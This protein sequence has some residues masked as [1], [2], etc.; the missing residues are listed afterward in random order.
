M[1]QKATHATPRMDLGV[2]FHEYSPTRMRFIA[3]QVM[4]KFP[5][6]K[7]AATLSVI[8][9]KNLTLPDTTRADGATFNRVSLYATDKSYSC[10]NDALEG[11]LPDGQRET[12]PDDFNAEL[13]TINALKIKMMLKRESRIKDKIFDTTTWTGA[14]LYTD[15]S[16]SPRDSVDTNIIS[17]IGA[18][19]EKV[20]LNTGVIADSLIIGE[21]AMQNMLKNTG[22]IARFPN[23]E[24]VT[25]AMIRGSLAA[26][27]GLE[28]LLVGSSAYNSADEG[29]DP[30][31]S[32]LW[33]DDYAMVAVL[34]REGMP[35][36][37]PQLARTIFWQRYIG[38]IDV[39]ALVEQ[40]REQQTKSDIFQVERSIDEKIIDEYFGHLMK[41][42]A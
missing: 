26:I 36:S 6:G 15:N 5:V 13:E 39:D 20:R 23:A 10:V 9:R 34:G 19:K 40:Y 27:F 12:Y 4:P 42:D 41:I 8:Q 22:I 3:D 21:A 38:D 14:A 25:E 33:G 24:R 31:F 18:A 11:V 30:T 28:Q 2:A 37:E 32:D 16:G 7:K 17:Q 29:Q 35:L 1:I